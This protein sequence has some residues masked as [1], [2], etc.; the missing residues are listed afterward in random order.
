MH[1]TMALAGCFCLVAVGTGLADIAP[2]GRGAGPEGYE[3]FRFLGTEDFPEYVFFFR[4]YSH[5]RKSGSALPRL[6]DVN[7]SE[8]LAAIG[9]C[10]D[11]EHLIAMPRKE[12]E[13]RK[14]Q[15]LHILQWGDWEQVPGLVKWPVYSKSGKTVEYRVMSENGQMVLSSPGFIESEWPWIAG[16]GFIAL[17]VISLGIWLA[18]RNRSAVHRV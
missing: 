8:P 3:E 16:G 7:G 10:I 5:D 6:V 18:R 4:Y 12:F 14:T 11:R 17:S 13:A 15:Y 9:Y 2:P 1:R